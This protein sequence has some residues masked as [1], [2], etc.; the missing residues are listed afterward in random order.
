MSKITVKIIPRSDTAANWTA[1]NPVLEPGELGIET[2][3][4]FMKIGDGSTSWNGL[5]YVNQGPPGPAGPAGADGPIGPEGPQGPPGPSGSNTV[6]PGKVN[7]D[8]SPDQLPTG[9]SSSVVTYNDNQVFTVTH[10]LG[11]TGYAVCGPGSI[12]IFDNY[13]T[14]T[15]YTYDY[16]QSGSGIGNWTFILAVL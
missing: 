3:T 15:D 14:V 4:R 9:W 6:H 12:G 2:D 7:G 5:G 13:F 11:H 1:A 16:Q 10:N 8:G